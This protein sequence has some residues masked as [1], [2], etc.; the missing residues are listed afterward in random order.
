MHVSKTSTSTQSNS[1]LQFPLIRW[2]DKMVFPSFSSFFKL[3]WIHFFMGSLFQFWTGL[4][5][6]KIHI[7]RPIWLLLHISDAMNN[8][9]NVYVNCF[10]NQW[11]CCWIP[12]SC[13]YFEMSDNFNAP[14]WQSITQECPPGFKPTSISSWLPLSWLLYFFPGSLSITHSWDQ[15]L[16]NSGLHQTPGSLLKCTILPPGFDLSGLGLCIVNKH[17]RGWVGGFALKKAGWCPM[18]CQTPNS[19]NHHFLPLGGN[20]VLLCWWVSLQPNLR[21]MNPLLTSHNLLFLLELPAQQIWALPS[22]TSS[23]PEASSIL[24]PALPQT[25]VQQPDPACLP[26]LQVLLKYSFLQL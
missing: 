15:Q 2:W 20:P 17:F 18:R 1:C 14:G 25:P 26:P 7:K 16:S 21:K 13:C 4:I 3:S 9:L 23:N 24:L 11:F 12:K 22:P 10:L 6:R 5:K 8:W 19:E